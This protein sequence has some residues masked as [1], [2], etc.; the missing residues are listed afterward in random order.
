MFKVN[1]KCLVAANY[2]VLDFRLS[3]SYDYDDT[4]V[5]FKVNIKCLV[6]ANG[7]Y[8]YKDHLPNFRA[9]EET[10]YRS[11]SMKVTAMQTLAPFNSSSN[12]FSS[13]PATTLVTNATMGSPTKKNLPKKL[14]GK[15]SSCSSPVAENL[16][17]SEKGGFDYYEVSNGGFHRRWCFS[18]DNAI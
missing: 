1:I 9:R 3:L 5:L 8:Y 18:F 17:D 4:N 6:A 10:K 13:L 14:S 12:M 2:I 11:F 7:G 15:E 16:G